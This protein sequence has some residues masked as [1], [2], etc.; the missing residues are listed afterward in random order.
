MKRIYILIVFLSYTISL[1]AIGQKD[2]FVGG[3]SAVY[4]GAEY[5]KHV[6]LKKCWQINPLCLWSNFIE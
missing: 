2:K 6:F 3:T 4:L 1:L 5:R